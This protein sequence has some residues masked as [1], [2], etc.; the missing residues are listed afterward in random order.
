MD[1][2]SGSD[3]A[4]SFPAA[5]AS[6]RPAGA[7]PGRP[8][9]RLVRTTG[10]LGRRARASVRRGSGAG[11]RD[12][13]R[14]AQCA[15]STEVLGTRGVGARP[16]ASREAAPETR[17]AEE[18]RREEGRRTD[19]P[20]RPAP[21]GPLLPLPLRPGKSED[22]E[23]GRRRRRSS[24]A[25]G[26]SERRR[27]PRHGSE[28]EHDRGRRPGPLSP[29]RRRRRGA[30][31]RRASRLERLLL[32]KRNQREENER[33]KKEGSPFF[34]RVRGIHAR[35]T[36]S[37]TVF[38]PPLPPTAGRARSP[39][40]GMEG[41]ARRAP[42]PSSSFALDKSNPDGRGARVGTKGGEKRKDGRALPPRSAGR[43]EGRRGEGGGRY[44]PMKTMEL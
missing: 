3:G 18:R 44:G 36:L 25:R 15:V 8:S 32:K 5:A 10:P 12:V 24:R 33:G 31:R 6:A 26:F 29:A 43:G 42:P 1:S 9:P 35:A 28:R 27:G 40:P 17:R 37:A 20:G 16:P 14:A 7:A 39:L 4:R 34:R 30:A 21:R 13:R 19:A 2:R 22:R 41:R 38:F 23:D 11:A